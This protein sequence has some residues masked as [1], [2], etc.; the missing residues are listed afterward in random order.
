[1]G[2]FEAIVAT[3]FLCYVYLMSIITIPKKFGSRDDLVVIPRHEYEAFPKWKRAVCVRV[4]E[5]WFWTPE[6]QK[7]EAEA[8][9]AIRYGNVSQGYAR[10]RE[11]ILALKHRRR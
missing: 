9:R 2:G 1:M 11:L 10:H 7:K 6:W 5:N 8:D 4:H 3:S